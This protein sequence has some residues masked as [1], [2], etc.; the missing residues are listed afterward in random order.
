MLLRTGMTSRLSPSAWLRA[1]QQQQQ[2]CTS[3]G[4]QAAVKHKHRCTKYG[5]GHASMYE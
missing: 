2:Q 5:W 3:I 4:K 1:R